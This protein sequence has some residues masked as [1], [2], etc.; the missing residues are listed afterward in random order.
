M[1]FFATTV[2]LALATH[3][4]HLGDY[5]IEPLEPGAD[6][7]RGSCARGGLH[8]TFRRFNLRSLS[9]A[10][11]TTPGGLV[12]GR[13]HAHHAWLLVASDFKLNHYLLT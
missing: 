5:I 3:F 4:L 8:T 12:V 9:K 2:L 1:F 11:P 7:G 13:N 10:L 6:T